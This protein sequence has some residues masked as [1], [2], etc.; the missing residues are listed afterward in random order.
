MTVNALQHTNSAT[1]TLNLND[2]S[3][4]KLRQT[5]KGIFLPSGKPLVQT[6]PTNIPPAVYQGHLFEPRKISIP[7]IVYGS[8]VDA[9]TDNVRALAAHFWPDM[10][11]SARG[12]LQY[13]TWGGVVRAIR[14]VLD[15]STDFDDWVAR[16][17]TAKGKVEIELRYLCP[18]PT[19]YNPTLVE[20]AATY[21]NGVTPVTVSCVN[22]GD[23]DTYPTITYTNTAVELLGNGDFETAGAGGA[24]VFDDWTETASDGAIADEGVD[25]HGGSHAAKLTAGATKDTRIS[26]TFTTTPGGEYAL[27]FWTH[28]DGANAG[29]YRIYDET[30]G[31]D[32]QALVTTG[33]AGAVYAE[34]TDTF[35][36][37]A[38]CTSVSLTFQ[39][40]DL[41]TAIAYFDDASV[42]QTTLQDPK[43]TDAYGNVWEIDGSMATGSTLVTCFDPSAIASTYS[44]GPA[45]WFG[46]RTPASQLIRC[47][48][49]TN[50]L[51]F[52][53]TS[54][55]AK[56]EVTFYSRYSAHG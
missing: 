17:Y 22:A 21:F 45:D 6:I 29:R 7:L 5:P 52:V 25:V 4:Y 55:A 50:N 13:E 49:G 51:T 39:C 41:N 15:P 27:S 47:K 20:P 42:Y 56:I 14:G 44:V 2:G 11:G 23:C 12:T 19:F 43:V 46:M 30:N 28:G 32:I 36:A 8:N 1:T 16:S 31:A 38:L 35:T 10:R 48:Y 34:V 40:P 24:D 9:L 3:T 37:P 53:C 26:Q 54:G 18:D 33:E